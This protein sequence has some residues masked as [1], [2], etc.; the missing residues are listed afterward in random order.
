MIDE[1]DPL[2]ST[3]QLR[4]ERDRLAEFASVLAHDLRNPL[5]V[6]QGRAALLDAETD[7]SE[8]LGPMIEGLDRMEVIIGDLLTLAKQ[9]DTLGETELVDLESIAT[10]CWETVATA[11]ATLAVQ[12][13]RS[14]EADSSRCKQLFENLYRNAIEHGGDAVTITVGTLPDGFYIADNG[15]GIEA[16]A[17]DQLFS[18]GYTTAEDGTGF[19]L[20]IADQIVRAHGWSIACVESADGGARFEITGVGE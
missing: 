19:G 14:V 9:G 8:H 4:S 13:S 7:A 6:A 18:L 17:R 20:S 5:T 15:A 12:D 16:D 3:P 1:A 11:D 2:M 10:A